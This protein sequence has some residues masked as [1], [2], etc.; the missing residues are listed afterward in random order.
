V[1]NVAGDG[2]VH[3]LYYDGSSW[4]DN[5]LTLFAGRLGMITLANDTN[6]AHT[7]IV[8]AP[9]PDASFTGNTAEWI[10]ETPTLPGGVAS[11]PKF[12]EVQFTA[13][14]CCGPGNVS[15]DPATGD[16][17]SIVEFGQVLTAETLAANAVTIDDVGP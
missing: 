12:T 10:V 14:V 1:L 5:D 4:V 7:S 17:T 9:P 11:L 16:A 15:G 2:H 8:L 13:A 6:G 3:E